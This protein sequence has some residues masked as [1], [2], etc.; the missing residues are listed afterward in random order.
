MT[1]SERKRYPTIVDGK[2]ANLSVSSINLFDVRHEGCPRKWYKRYVQGVRSAETKA[3]QRGT[4]IHAQIEHYLKTGED[5]LSDSVRAGKHFIPHALHNESYIV[6]YEFGPGILS[7]AGIPINGKIDFMHTAPYEWTEQGINKTYHLFEIIDWKTLSDEKYAKKGIDLEH[8]TQMLGYAQVAAS[9]LYDQEYLDDYQSIRLSQVYFHTKKRAAYRSTIVTEIGTVIKNWE[10]V[11]SVVREMKDVAQEKEFLKVP[12]NWNACVAY[13]GCPHR[14]ECPRSPEQAIFDLLGK[15]R[16][17]SLLRRE[18]K[19]TTPNPA[20]LRRSPLGKPQQED[21]EEKE[22]KRLE[23]QLAAKKGIRYTKEE[24]QEDPECADCGEVL[25]AD[26]ASK[27]RSGEWKHIGCPE[28]TAD[29]LPPDAP[30]SN[31]RRSAEPVPRE[32][33]AAQS[34][35]VRRAI[36]EHEAEAESAPA[37][38]AEP[39]KR[40]RKPKAVAP[41]EIPKVKGLTLYVDC[42]RDG[43]EPLQNLQTYMTDILQR[44]CAE[45]DCVDIRVGNKESP[46]AFGGWRGVLASMI[47]AE[48]PAPGEYAIVSGGDLGQVLIETLSEMVDCVVRGVR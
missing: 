32:Q 26:N 48:P 8:D 38:A 5:N 40:G 17:M 34:P 21:E 31:A 4:E 20:A 19:E 28:R 12:P 24:A 41:V 2:L 16:G 36:A 29:V 47:R 3:Q 46:L 45:Y 23:A 1:L 43:G 9:I 27:L 22:I 18:Q 7:S 42:Y 14:A 39:A 13:G 37:V 25:T 33:V 44:I 11:E 6:E 15:G 30:P 10:P 35:R